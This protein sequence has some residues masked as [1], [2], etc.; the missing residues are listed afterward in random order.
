M[1]NISTPRRYT[2]S[3]YSLSQSECFRA[4]KYIKSISCI[5]ELKRNTL[6]TPRKGYLAKIYKQHV[7]HI[8]KPNNN[9][10]VDSKIVVSTHKKSIGL[11]HTASSIYLLHNYCII[12]PNPINK[13]SIIL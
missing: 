2:Q 8:V 7:L 9:Y 11:Q 5:S 13:L 10:T 12:E 3:S 1:Q 4:F 6:V